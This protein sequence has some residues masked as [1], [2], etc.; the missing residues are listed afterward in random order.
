LILHIKTLVNWVCLILCLDYFRLKVYFNVVLVENTISRMLKRT[1]F[2]DIIL[3][4]W[5]L[6]LRDFMSHV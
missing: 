3:F 2:E 5:F 4:F 6:I 1:H